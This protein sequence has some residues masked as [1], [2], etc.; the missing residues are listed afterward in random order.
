MGSGPP[1]MKKKKVY[2]SASRIGTLQKCSW[3]YYTKYILHMPDTPNEG[4]LR[5]SICHTV[6]EVLLKPRHKAHYDALVEKNSIKG[7]KAI[8]KMVKSYMAKHPT[9]T[10][11]NYKENYE[12][13]DKMI[14]VGLKHNFFGRD[15]GEVDSPEKE[16]KIENKKPKYNIYGFMDKPVRYDKENLLKIVDY[17]SSKNKFRGDE[18]TS[19]VQAMMYSLAARKLWP[20]IKK[21]IVQFLF[22]KFPRSPKQELEFNKD[23]LKGFEYYLEEIQSLIENFDETTA[24]S[25]FAANNQSKWL[26]GP[27]KS[28][29]ICPM[30]KPFD[31]YALV[32]EGD[33]DTVLKTSFEN[34]IT[35]EKGQK[36]VKKFYEGCPH[37]YPR[38]TASASEEEKDLFDF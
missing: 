25:N 36:V 10:K 4:M 30:Q 5:G 9:F 6:F 1:E 11:E 7:S 27:A 35:P 20:K 28:G 12:L 14:I 8:N 18:L 33:E 26:C 22:L 13:I 21:I 19:N 34:D 32:K 15:G 37:F 3:L 2:L 23:E 24:K 29:W 16:F 38:G 17:K 31:F